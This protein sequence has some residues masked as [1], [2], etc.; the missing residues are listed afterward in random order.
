MN[1][2]VWVGLLWSDRV[3]LALQEHGDQITDVSIFGWQ[4]DKAGNLTQTFNPDLLLPYRARW[5]HL[6]FWLAFRNDGVASIAAALLAN[7]AARNRL[8]AGLD[9]ALTARPWLHGVDIDL[10]RVGGAQ[11]A[12]PA[13]ALFRQ[14]AAVAHRHGGQCSAALPPL[15]STGSVGGENWARY[16]QLG[17]ILDHLSIMSYDFAWSGS[18]PGPVSPGYWMHDVYD[19]AVSQVPA[20][21]LSMGLPLY[22]YFWMIHNS[23]QALGRTYR[24]DSG[25]YYS[26]WQQFTGYSAWDG[27][28][29]GQASSHHRIGWV[30]FRDADSSSAWGMTSVY[31][32]RY[33]PD[34]DPG[35]ASGVASGTYNGHP[36]TVRYGKPSGSPLF[37]VADNSARGAGSNFTLLPA[38]VRDADGALVGPKKGYTLTVE[39]LRRLP[40]AAT[41]IDDNATTPD[42]LK[43]VYAVASGAWSQWKSGTYGQYRGSGSFVVNHDF[44]AQALYV[45]VKGQFAAAGWAGV[46]VRGLTAEV[47]N[48]G[49]VRLRNGST[50]LAS[51]SVSSRPVGAAAGNGQFVL[52]LRV[53]DGS[54]RVYYS[55][56][57]ARLVPTVLTVNTTPPGGPSGVECAATTWIDHVYVGDGWWYQPREAVTVQVGAAV[58]TLGRIPRSGVTWDAY[59]RFRPNADVDE[60]S[61]RSESVSLDWDYAHWVDAPLTTGR[62]AVVRVVAADHDVWLGRVLAVDRDGASIIYWTDAETVGRWRDE[63]RYR[64]GLAGIALWTLGQEDLR[65]WDRLAGGEL[66]AAT[67]R[68]NS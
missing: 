56:S 37:S 43:T 50:V 40:V 65:T 41:I 32:W 4:V 64:Y 66:P 53:R 36:Y 35:S 59:N 17:Q 62:A 2:W 26:A 21:K 18:A 58:R 25:T 57:E 10:E 3:R 28:T 63:A 60:Q 34:F 52:G 14:V 61:T 16:R 27:A 39:A 46:T 47:S 49:T 29:A 1:V 19:W 5:P 54:A 30:A 38:A 15:T 9:A 24:G 11:N 33:A 13:E 42:Q 22:A 12:A 20:G 7:A 51:G 31:D 6:R 48:G 23:P 67:K 55:D 8:V 45:Q 44:G 68:L